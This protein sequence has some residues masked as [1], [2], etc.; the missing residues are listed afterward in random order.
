MT[1]RHIAM[2][3]ISF[4]YINKMDFVIQTLVC[5]IFVQVLNG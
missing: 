4:N 5:S 2:L 3:L 1:P